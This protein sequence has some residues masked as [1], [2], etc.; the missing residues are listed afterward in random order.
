MPID[1]AAAEAFI[2]STARLLD[3][4]RYAFLFADGPA[5]PVIEALRAYR[6]PDGGFGHA[7]EPD[8]RCPSSQPSPTLYALEILHEAGAADGE[9]ASGARAWLAEIAGSDGSI[10]SVLPDFAGYP[11]APWYTAAPESMLTFAVVA[12]CH[13]GGQAEGE[14]LA[15]ATDWCWRSIETREQP[16]GY[17]LKFA[18]AF[19]DAV[20]EEERARAAI[21]SL[22]GRVDPSAVEPV[23]GVEGERL[24]P[25]DLSPR[26]GSRSRELVTQ[27]QIEAH[28]DAVQSE[29][30]Q[31]G[32]WTFD[33]LAWSPAQSA[34]WRGIVTI[35]ALT[36]LRDNG[37]LQACPVPVK[38]A[39]VR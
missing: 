7:L 14:W 8:V 31:D 32:G 33:W 11:H 1:R 4:H 12:A 29:Q 2:W 6:N 25:L 21:A 3:R 19:L 17:W 27:T 15:R 30:H 16:A 18:L 23:G 10:P 34:E 9:L 20:P 5:D 26:P 13:D 39:N 28:L 35:R 22:A 24:R 37:R 36:W 38:N